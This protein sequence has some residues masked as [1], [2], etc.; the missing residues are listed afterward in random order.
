M[1]SRLKSG[2]QRRG[3]AMT[4]IQ[5]KGVYDKLRQRWP[6]LEWAMAEQM[7]Q[8]EPGEP[9]PRKAHRY[10]PHPADLH[11]SQFIEDEV[12]EEE[13]LSQEE[14]EELTPRGRERTPDGDDLAE[15]FGPLPEQAQ[16]AICRTYANYLSARARGAGRVFAAPQHSRR[17]KTRLQ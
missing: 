13:P 3:W 17:K 1:R 10:Y 11:A 5:Y 9:E 2:G 14:E 16:I 15:F 6:K 12:E 7:R 4:H 8:P